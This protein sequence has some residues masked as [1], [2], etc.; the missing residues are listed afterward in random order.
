MSKGGS[1]G[2]KGPGS[3]LTRGKFDMVCSACIAF[4]FCNSRPRADPRGAGGL[5]P[6]DQGEIPHGVLSLHCFSIL[7]LMS[8]GGSKESRG[9]GPPLTRWKFHMMCSACIALQFVTS[10]PQA[11]PRGVG[12]WAPLTRG[13][14]YIVCSACIAFRFGTSCLRAGPKRSKGPGDP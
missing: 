9:P 1:K 5:V 6:L 3:P 11:D 13:K 4:Q 2:S 10:F 7:H 8:K 12:A 14:F